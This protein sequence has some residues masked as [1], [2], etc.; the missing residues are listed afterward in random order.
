MLQKTSYYEN[1]KLDDDIDVN[2]VIEV[3][4]RK[5]REI[6]HNLSFGCFKISE[7]FNN[8][9]K[10]SED[11]IEKLE[12]EFLV[13]NLDVNTIAK[14]HGRTLH[15][16]ESKVSELNF[17]CFKISKNL[18]IWEENEIEQLKQ[19][20]LIE[21]KDI[22]EIAKTHK[23]TIKNIQNKCNQ[24]KLYCDIELNN[25]SKKWLYDEVEQLKQEYFIEKKDI[26]EISKIHKRPVG[27]IKVKINKL[28]SFNNEKNRK[29][30]RDNN[31]KQYNKQKRWTDDEINQ[32]KHEYL[33]FNLDT[34]ANIHKR[35]KHSIECQIFNLKKKCE[36]FNIKPRKKIK[37]SIHAK[38]SLDD[39]GFAGNFLDNNIFNSNMLNNDILNN[40]MSDNE[41][42]NNTKLDNEIFNNNTIS[43]DEIFNNNMLNNKSLNNT[44]AHDEIFNNNVLNNNVLNNKG[45]NNTISHDE[46]FNNNMLNNKGLNNTISHDEN[47]NKNMLDNEELDNILS[48][49]ALNDEKL[50]NEFGYN[51]FQQTVKIRKHKKRKISKLKQYII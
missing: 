29:K 20:I 18:N 19:E 34:I 43:H 9:K 45:L 36:V 41:K 28:N 49:D 31:D 51:V 22:N 6:Q 50:E 7:H 5:L 37:L 48:N 13:D 25:S 2:M 4:E 26:G 35:G 3:H 23:R 24:L 32:L 21:K 27:G 46:I 14:N 38:N 1:E 12:Q 47:F 10:W 15:A 17:C 33:I 30:L 44:I 11:E 42:S 16:I 40:I 39:C 8:R